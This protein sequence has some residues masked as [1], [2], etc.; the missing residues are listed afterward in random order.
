MK[1]I[2]YSRSV[3]LLSTVILSFS[4]GTTSAQ[5]TTSDDVLEE[6][7]TIGTRTS[8]RSVIDSPVPIDVLSPDDLRQSGA[9]QGEVGELIGALLPSAIMRRNSNS[10]LADVV[11]TVSLRGLSASQ[12]LVLVNGKRRHNISIVAGAA[13]DLNNIPSSSIKRIEVLRDGAAAQ[14]GSDAIAGVINI[15]LKDADEGGSLSATYGAHVTEFEPTASDMTDGQT[16][17]VLGN[18]GFKLNEGGFLNVSAEFRNREATNRGGAPASIPPFFIENQ[19]PPNL[20][21]N[22]HRNFRAGDSAFTDINTVFNTERRFSEKTDL[23]AFGSFSYREGEGINFFRFPDSSAN[24]PSI[25][26]NGFLPITDTKQL[27]YSVAV[28]A[29]SETASNWNWDASVTYGANDFDFDMSN[30]LNASLGTASPTEFEVADYK[31]QDIILNFD[32]SKPL[33]VDMFNN[34]LHVAYGVEYRHEN[35]ETE[36]G[37][38]ASY[39]AGPLASSGAP[40]GV[41]GNGGLRPQDTVDESRDEVAVYLDLETNINDRFLLGAAGRFEYYSDFGET[42]NGK[43]TAR[44]EVTPQFALRGTISTGF[45]APSLTQAFFKGGTTDFAATSNMLVSQAFL[46]ANDPIAQLL[47][48]EELDAEESFNYSL[49]FTFNTDFGFNLTVDVYQI[50]IDKR[51]VGSQTIGGA[52]VTNFINSNLGIADIQSLR[53]F[54]NAIDTETKGI[55]IVADYTFDVTAASKLNLRAAGSY[56]VTNVEKVKANPA[57]LNTLGIG[58]VIFGDDA[59]TGTERGRPRAKVVLSGNWTTDRLSI[60]LRGSYL[61]TTQHNTPF[62]QQHHGSEWLLDMDLEYN[63]TKNISVA[64]GGNNILDNYPDLT[65]FGNSFFGNLPYDVVTP[66]GMNGAYYYARISYNF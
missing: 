39:V 35:Y 30:S 3:L 38:E 23:Y 24:V 57:V 50:D 66:I 6:I 55:D 46:P 16:I 65:V 59:I 63:L 31:Y 43:I 51:I 14:Y 40:I 44:Y 27:D 29:K 49:G 13:V 15:V 7:I 21:L 47:G 53:Y 22:G 32:M 60:L 26:P 62:G 5:N 17:Y 19:T 1:L 28:G 36:S 58:A 25:H 52:A 34:P 61:G 37:D 54:T 12:T 8:G 4:A 33:D 10:D 64:I 18:K 20:A 2:H 45:R 56:A 41:Q 42:I 11:R 9:L 48:A